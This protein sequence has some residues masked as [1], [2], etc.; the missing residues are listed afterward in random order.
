MPYT[1]G[2]ASKRK[3]FA[4]HHD[5][6]LERITTT[7][8]DGITHSYNVAEIQSI[9]R[10][11][12]A[13]FGDRFFPL[14]NNVARLGAGTERPGLGTAI[15]AQQPGDIYHAQGASCLGVVLEHAAYR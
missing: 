5:P 1:R 4:C 15:L 7:S 2:G 12:H 8:D 10:Q 14:A 3:R 6:Q 13:Q 9:L 11:L